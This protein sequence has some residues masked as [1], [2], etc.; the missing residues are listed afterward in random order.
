MVVTPPDLELWLCE[1]LRRAFPSVE[2]GN[3]EPESLRLPL[4]RPLIVVRDDSGFRLSHVTFDRAV[5]VSVL[6]GTR[7][8]DRQAN[9]LA[10][11][12]AGVLM[13]DS[14]ALVND[15]PIAAVNWDGCCG[16]YAV[17]DKMDVARR[18]L[19]VEYTVVGSWG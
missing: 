1:H 3:K 12:V 11:Q 18:Y 8:N 2:T 6:A 10:R 17:V 7:S 5:G 13:D 9:D 16:P 14:I 15:S 19:T 4:A